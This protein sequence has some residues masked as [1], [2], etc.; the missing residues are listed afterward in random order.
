[1]TEVKYRQITEI[2][3]DKL[4]QL[5]I[6]NNFYTHGDCA[7][8][9]RMFDMARE[10]AG[11]LDELLAVAEDIYAHS[12]IEELKAFT[13]SGSKRK[14]TICDIIINYIERL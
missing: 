9:S 8:Y 12:G 10:Y 13:Y 1:M 3:C 14:D 7:A 6:K 4:R 11:G 5:C 2:D